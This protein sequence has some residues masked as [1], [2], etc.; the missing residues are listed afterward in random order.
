MITEKK[1][2]RIAWGISGSGDRLIEVI[3]YMKKIKKDYQNESRITIYLSKAGDQVINYYRL[4]K[5]LIENF[6]KVRIEM[7]S[8]LPT[9]AI[10]LQSGKIEFL[11]IAPA[12]SNTVAKIAAGI[13]DTL[14]CNAAIMAMKSVIPVYILPC[15]FQEGITTTRLPDGSE[16]NIRIRK[17][18][19]ENVKKLKLMDGIIIIENIKDIK[20]IFQK[21]LK[22]ENGN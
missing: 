21:H 18:D 20:Q 15:D 22:I 13:G 17:E 16:M 9:L 6:E 1:K 5:D 10:Q 14:L 4:N 19:V 3:E 8:N 12:T 7:N 2:K 11:L